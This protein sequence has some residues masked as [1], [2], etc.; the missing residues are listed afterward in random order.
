MESTD[1]VDAAP[2]TAKLKIIISVLMVLRL[3]PWAAP[4][5]V[6]VVVVDTI[7]TGAR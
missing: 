4:V 2:L 7:L 1:C 6:V 5:V 3:E